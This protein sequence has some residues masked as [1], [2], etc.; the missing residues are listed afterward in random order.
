MLQTTHT[1]FSHLLLGKKLDEY[2]EMDGYYYATTITDH[3]ETKAFKPN[4][5]RYFVR[6][7]KEVYIFMS[8][9]SF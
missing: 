8:T 2:V 3:G 9:C 5:F 6:V 4:V 1:P 7:S